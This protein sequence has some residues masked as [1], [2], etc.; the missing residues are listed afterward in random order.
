MRRIINYI[1]IKLHLY[2]PVVIYYDCYEKQQYLTLSIIKY[3]LGGKFGFGNG[4]SKDWYSGVYK[5]GKWCQNIYK[6][7]KQCGIL[8][9]CGLTYGYVVLN[10]GFLLFGGSTLKETHFG[11]GQWANKKERYFE[12][13]TTFCSF[14]PM[15][16]ENVR[17]IIKKLS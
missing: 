10:K 15:T 7:C 8:E 17:E 4:W 16:Q 3:P 13:V 1:L 2:K 9:S 6:D 11:W 14:S 5:N 12:N